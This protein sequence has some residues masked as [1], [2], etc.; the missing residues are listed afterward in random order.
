MASAKLSVDEAASLCKQSQEWPSFTSLS[1]DTRIVNDLQNITSAQTFSQSEA[2]PVTGEGADP[3]SN[4]IDEDDVCEDDGADTVAANQQEAG[5]FS[6]QNNDSAEVPLPQASTSDEEAELS[7]KVEQESKLELLEVCAA[8]GMTVSEQSFEQFTELLNHP[9]KLEEKRRAL[10][11][12]M[13]ADSLRNE[14]LQNEDADVEAFVSSFQDVSIPLLPP[15]LSEPKLEEE[16][17]P[18]ISP[19][20]AIANTSG[21]PDVESLGAVVEELANDIAERYGSSSPISEAHSVKSEVSNELFAN[22]SKSSEVKLLM[23]SALTD[24][25]NNNTLAFS[26]EMPGGLPQPPDT[27]KE[28][29]RGKKSRRKAKKAKKAAASGQLVGGAEEW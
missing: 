19:D 26:E 4:S 11:E 28:S 27:G 29:G 15:V 2:N 18:E 7:G 23:P 14:A 9:E 8:H 6:T 3:L 17:V 12:F 24:P 22:I 25:L 16:S 10:E 13:E 1:D 21:K 5:V 20:S